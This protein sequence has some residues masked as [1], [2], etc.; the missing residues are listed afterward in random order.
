MIEDYGD[1]NGYG[2]LY[3]YH[4]GILYISKSVCQSIQAHGLEQVR[5]LIP[6]AL[7]VSVFLG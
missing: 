4:L 3:L 6:I 5:N 1:F 2:N 7:D